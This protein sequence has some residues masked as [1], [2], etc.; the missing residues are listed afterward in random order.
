[1]LGVYAE[2]DARVNA[3]REAADAALTAAGLE[4]RSSPFPGATH[5]FFND[6]GMSYNA[7]AAEEPGRG[8]SPGSSSI[9]ADALQIVLTG[10][11]WR[12]ENRRSPQGMDQVPP[13]R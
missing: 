9:W 1:M 10:M 12:R 8:C 4:T 11:R 3:T 5:A 2:L 13:R 6:T 7:A